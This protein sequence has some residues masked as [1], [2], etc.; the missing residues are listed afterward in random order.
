MAI[1]IVTYS[2]SRTQS[3]F[4][5]QLHLQW[6]IHVEL[7][8]WWMKNNLNL[9][10]HKIIY[11]FYLMFIT[12]FINNISPMKCPSYIQHV[13]KYL[14]INL[15]IYLSYHN[16][17][18]NSRLQSVWWIKHALAFPF[19]DDVDGHIHVSYCNQWCGTGGRKLLHDITVST[20]NFTH[21]KLSQLLS[22]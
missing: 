7:K 13:R 3:Q 17:V 8:K 5:L 12:S 2:K 9:I 16:V 21:F 22:F 4:N 11:I 6:R 1:Y 14:C 10:A 20:Y 19:A 15:R 18:H